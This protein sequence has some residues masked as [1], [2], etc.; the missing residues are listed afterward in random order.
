[1]PS[2]SLVF[3]FGTSLAIH[4][5]IL[6]TGYWCLQKIILPQISV[7]AGAGAEMGDGSLAARDSS[8]IPVES[9]PLPAADRAPVDMPAAVPSMEAPA[10]EN[11]A[12]SSSQE[13]SGAGPLMGGEMV[14]DEAA[15]GAFQVEIGVPQIG[16][17]AQPGSARGGLATGE[18]QAT[19]TGA[20]GDGIAGGAPIALS[21]NKQPLY[22][23]ESRRRGEEGTVLLRVDIRVDGKVGE[24]S[25]VTSSGS[26]LLDQAAIEAVQK[27][28]FE[29]AQVNGSPQACQVNL[30]VQFVLKR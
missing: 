19:G 25:V 4:G 6:G 30:P 11:T 23:L 21:R 5:A 12:L 10:P 13:I 22:P 2:R 14:S 3:S 24:V 7:Q 16:L 15:F 20:K 17:I 28:V 29:P 1:M 9:V 26:S 8:E 18:D 27:W